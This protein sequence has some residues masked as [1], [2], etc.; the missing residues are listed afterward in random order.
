MEKDRYKDQEEVFSNMLRAGNRS[1]FF[2]VKKTKKDDFYI[3]ITE[4]K[5]KF[6][7]SGRYFFEKHKLFLY[8]E[9]FENFIAGLQEAVEIASEN[10]AQHNGS[11]QNYVRPESSD[12]EYDSDEIIEKEFVNIEFEDLQD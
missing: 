2:D 6:K 10:N 9:D 7:D 8:K 3:T 5:K 4:S 12:K 1:Y 11:D